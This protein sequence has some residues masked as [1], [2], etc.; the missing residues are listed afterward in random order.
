[1]FQDKIQRNSEGY[2][3]VELMIAMT[4]FAF[5]SL[6]IIVGTLQAR[7]IAENNIRQATALTVANGFLEQIRGLDYSSLNNHRTSGAPF[8]FVVNGMEYV[9]IPPYVDEVPLKVPMK[10][11]P[12]KNPLSLPMLLTI[13][14]RSIPGMQAIEISIVYKWESVKK[15]L[16]HDEIKSIQS[17]IP[18]F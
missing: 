14:L 11:S 4:L 3:L 9:S 17:N 10:V 18:S 15:Q 13:N 5:I 16:R 7:E 2:S 1:M 8:S 6:G 12:E